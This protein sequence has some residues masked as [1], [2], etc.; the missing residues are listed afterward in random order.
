MTDD[1]R[2]RK[3]YVTG[4]GFTRAFNPS[5]PLQIDDFNNDELVTKFSY[6]P[7]AL[8]LL[9][10]ERKSRRNGFINI[11]KLISRLDD[12]MP[13]DYASGAADEFTFLLVELKQ[14]L[15]NRISR[16]RETKETFEEINVFARHCIAESATL[17]GITESGV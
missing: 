14:R 4:A 1:N 11:E 10:E 6:L 7:H 13:Y 12:L 17:R 8:S 16:T 15:L 3:V 9:E 2:T 5:S